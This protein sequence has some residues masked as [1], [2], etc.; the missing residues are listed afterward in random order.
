MKSLTKAAIVA[1]ALATTATPMI[2]AAQDRGDR[3]EFRQERREDR[4]EYREDRRDNRQDYRRGEI[5]QR[6]FQREQRDDR[7]D[8][9]QDRRGDRQ[10]YRQD[11][12]RDQRWDRGNRNWYQ[13][14][15]DHRDYRGA[16]NGYWYAPSYGYYR[17]Q[18]RYYNQSW[19]RGG[20]LPRPIAA[21][22]CVIR[23]PTICGPHRAA[24]ATSMPATTSF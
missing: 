16:R 8:F 14:R 3:R 13:G 1:L 19:Q 17:V 6:Q 22:M 10:D 20:Y 15:A 11:V 7:R 21:T 2:A 9:R 5:N 23:M 4:R 24:I 18:P 12:R